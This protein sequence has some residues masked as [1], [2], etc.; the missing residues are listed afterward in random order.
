MASAVA[1]VLVKSGRL[2]GTFSQ[3]SPPSVVRT[4][5]ESAPVGRRPQNGGGPSASAEYITRG[6]LGCLTSGTEY[7]SEKLVPI[8]DQLAPPSRLRYSARPCARPA[9]ASWPPVAT[10]MVWG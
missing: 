6:L 8:G 7:S 1:K 9:R 10:T 3:V 2:T 5:R 4:M